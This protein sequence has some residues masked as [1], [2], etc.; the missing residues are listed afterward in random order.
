MDI[1]IVNNQIY[2][3]LKIGTKSIDFNDVKLKNND[4]NTW[5]QF[6]IYS[7]LHLYQIKSDKYDTNEIFKKLV[8]GDNVNNI[9]YKEFNN[10]LYNA[11]VG[12]NF[13]IDDITPLQYKALED[14]LKSNEN[15][16]GKCYATRK[17]EFDKDCKEKVNVLNKNTKCDNIK[18]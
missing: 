12:M 10:L 16:I 8:N 15:V 13:M 3:N 5:K 4:I 17:F 7:F 6:I 18:L 14:F 2:H 9:S 11:L 1:N